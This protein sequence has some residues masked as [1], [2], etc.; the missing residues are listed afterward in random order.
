MSDSLHYLDDF[1]FTPLEPGTR[2]DARIFI[3]VMEEAQQAALLVPSTLG[4]GENGMLGAIM[5]PA[6]YANLPGAPPPF[7]PPQRSP[8]LVI[9]AG[10][11]ALGQANMK[12]AHKAAIKEWRHWDYFKTTVSTKLLKIF[13]PEY[14]ESVRHPSSS[15]ANF[16]PLRS[17]P[18]LEPIMVASPWMISPRTRKS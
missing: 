4:R 1:Q 6:H 11:N 17:L 14:L 9:P 10:T 16:N 7:V 12:A 3:K 8:T 15:S 13:G 2:P 5:T 18:A